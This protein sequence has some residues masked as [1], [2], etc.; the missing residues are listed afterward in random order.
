MYRC[1]DLDRCVCM[2]YIGYIKYSEKY[3]LSESSNIMIK[4][5]FF[6][7]DSNDCG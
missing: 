4:A 6:L 5:C 7:I 2:I 3:I 1:I